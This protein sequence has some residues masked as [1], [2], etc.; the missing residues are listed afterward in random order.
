MVAGFNPLVAKLFSLSTSVSVHKLFRREPLETY[1]RGRAVIIGDAAHPIQP[2]HAQDAVLAIEEAA[3]LEALFKHM[4]G[5][6][7]VAERLGLYNDILKRR[8]HVTQLLSDA[9]PGISSI[10]RKRAEDIWGEGIFPPEAMNFT[11]PI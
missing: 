7:M 10:L 9:Q 1:T 2:T 3:A 6:E 11:K 5:P 8:I 4:Q